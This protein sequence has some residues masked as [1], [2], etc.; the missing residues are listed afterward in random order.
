MA[1]KYNKEVWMTAHSFVIWFT[2]YFKPIVENYCL[3]KKIIF[4]LL[5]LIDN[6]QDKEL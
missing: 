6:V 1:Y 4:K 5:L 2:E 3:K